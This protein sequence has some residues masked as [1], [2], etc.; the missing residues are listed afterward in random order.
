MAAQLRHR[1]KPTSSKIQKWGSQ[2]SVCLRFSPPTVSHHHGWQQV[3]ACCRGTLKETESPSCGCAGH[4]GSSRVLLGQDAVQFS[5]PSLLLFHTAEVMRAQRH[6][7][8]AARKQQQL[9][10]C[11]TERAAA[12][13]S[14]LYRPAAHAGHPHPSAPGSTQRVLLPVLERAGTAW[15]EAA[16]GCCPWTGLRRCCAGAQC[17]SQSGVS[18]MDKCSMGDSRAL[19]GR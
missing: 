4:V 15:P 7:S 18:S 6:A 2:L 17:W 11:R 16:A 1:G 19:K 13:A 14:P 9:Q 3:I 5:L 12:V 8:T 10:R